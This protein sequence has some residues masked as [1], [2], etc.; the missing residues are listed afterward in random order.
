MDP[1]QRLE[2]A[3]VA[4]RGAL[5]VARARSTA[6]TW[7]RVLA[8]AKNLRL[9]RRDGER[10]LRGSAPRRPAGE[11]GPAAPTAAA[12]PDAKLLQLGHYRAASREPTAGA[13]PGGPAPSSSTPRGRIELL[14]EIE[15]AHALVEDAR[16]LGQEARALRDAISRLVHEWSLGL[17]AFGLPDPGT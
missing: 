2:L 1:A 12:R 15:R 9:A 13:A 17:G 6:A 10:V 14:R 16:R 3:L 11:G 7:K 4:Y 5:A 8:A